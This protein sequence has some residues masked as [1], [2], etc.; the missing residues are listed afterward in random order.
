VSILELKNIFSIIDDYDLFLFDLWGVVN[1]GDSPYLEVI[2]TINKLV[3]TKQILFVTNAPRPSSVIY[4]RLKN[5][6]LNLTPEMIVTSGEIAGQ[7]IADSQTNFNISNPVIYHLGHDRNPDIETIINH[8]ITKYI[9]EANIMLMTCARTESEDLEEFDN[10]LQLAAKNA[11]INICANPDIISPNLG[12][13]TYC[14]GYFASRLESFGGEVIYTGKPDKAIYQE[15]FAKL[16]H[17]PKN[18]ILMV[19]DTFCTDILGANKAGIDSALVLTGNAK[20]FHEQ[21]N[22]I[23]EKL[24]HLKRAS[25]KEGVIPSFVIEL[26]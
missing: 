26:C 1:E 14:S 3:K 10:L 9:H 21:Y 23:D 16:P 15:A 18:R 17:I 24:M 7:L 11:I 5:W 4:T 20:S 12:V 2:N 8:K 13:N 19:G 6:G 22:D 25:I